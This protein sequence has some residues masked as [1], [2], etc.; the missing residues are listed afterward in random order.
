MKV[1]TEIHFN[2]FSTKGGEEYAEHKVG[3]RGVVGIRNECIESLECYAVDFEDGRCELIYN[4]NRVFYT[5]T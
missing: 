2:W 4:P 1:I 5:T 3:E